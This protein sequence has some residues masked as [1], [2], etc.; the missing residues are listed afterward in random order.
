MAIMQRSRRMAD[1][2]IRGETIR[3]DDFDKVVVKFRRTVK[4]VKGGK[5]FSIGALVVI[6]DKRG[7]VAW[8]YG[9][10]V[11]VPFAVDKAVRDAAKRLI[12]VPVVG[13]TVPHT[14]ERKVSATYVMIRSAC[15]GTGIKAGLSVRPVLELAGV[16]DVITKV[17][18]STNPINVVKAT[19]NC[20]RD[21]RT[22]GQIEK[23]RGVRAVGTS[24]K[25]R[26]DKDKVKTPA[27][28]AAAS[29]DEE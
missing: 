4:V 19:Y 17:R 23:M 18:G 27:V 9:K 7:R 24:L 28:A 21:L 3:L 1:V 14:I 10:A 12:K 11:E 6:G 15:P 16:R 5:R 8:G 29:K 2:I 13:T 26:E 25:P 22:M 20:L